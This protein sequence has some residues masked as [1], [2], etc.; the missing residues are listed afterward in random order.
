MGEYLR[1]IFKEGKPV[2]R[3]YWPDSRYIYWNCDN[4]QF[5]NEQNEIIEVN[6]TWD[7]DNDWNF[8]ERKEFK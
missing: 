8:W 4:H 7:E 2:R 6:E 3:G 5:Y 1:N